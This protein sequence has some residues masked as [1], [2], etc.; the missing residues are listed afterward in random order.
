MDKKKQI[1]EAI[2]KL[3]GKVGPVQSILATVVSVD[4]N[5]FTC[6]IDDGDNEI[7]DVRLRPVLNGNESMTLVPKVDSF[8]LAVRIEEDEEW[9]IVATDEIDKFRVKVGTLEFEMDGNK[10]LLKKGSE[11]L[12]KMADDL[13]D[14]MLAEKHLTNTGVTINLTPASIA[15]YQA[16]KARF[17]LFLKDA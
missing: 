1:R 9:M 16:L 10:F 7:Y 4:V 8:V 11:N 3:A 15:Q 12:K 14:A 2:S 13:F 6:V 17:A 5:E